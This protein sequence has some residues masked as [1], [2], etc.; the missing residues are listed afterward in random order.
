MQTQKLF[1]T[2]IL[3]LIV[4]IV[5][6]VV[7][8]FYDEPLSALQAATLRKLVITMSVVS[9]I[10]FVVGEL[11]RNYSQTDKLWSI[12]PFFYVLYVADAETGNRVCC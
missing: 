5:I 4:L 9:F 12:M 2:V 1:T 11:T 7:A 6:P 10:C 3:L 8:I